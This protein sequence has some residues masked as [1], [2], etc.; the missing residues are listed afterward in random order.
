[1]TVT[2]SDPFHDLGVRH[3]AQGGSIRVWSAHATAMELCLFHRH[4]PGWVVDTVAL[5]RDEHGVWSGS[6]PD[7]RAGRNYSVRVDG[8][9]QPGHH[10]LP[11]RHLLDPYARGLSRTP[12]G[13][14]RAS[15]VDTG[16][17]WDG[18]EAPTTP[19]ENSVI[20]EAH[21]RGISKLNPKVPA[22]LRG[23]YAGLAH[24]SMLDYFVDL[25]VTAVQLLPVHQF[26]SEQRLL[27]LGMTNYWGYNTLNFFTP[28]ARYASAAAV[29]AGPAAILRE[30]KSMVKA[31]HRAGLQVFMDVVY[32]HTAEEGPDGPTT[33]FRGID[34]AS[35]YRQMADGGYIDMTGCGNTLDFSKP[36]AQR[37]V[38]D[39]LR[40]WAQ[41][42]HIDG[43]RFDLAPALGR[44]ADGYFDPQHPLLT[45]IV[46]DPGL[47]GVTMIAEPWDV[48]TDGWQTG[49]FPAGWAEWNDGYRG[50]M[51][52]F[53]LTDV[54]RARSQGRAAEG[55]GSMARRFAGSA[56]VFSA[57][58]GPLASINFVTAHDGFTL[59]DVTAY[60]QKHNLPNGENNRDGTDD[61]RSF[62]HGVE[63][64]TEN[65]DVLAA[66][67]KAMRN[68]LGTL[69]LSA[70]VPQLTA[71]D[72]FGRT[73]HGN[74][75]AYCH[76]DETTWVSWEWQPWQQELHEVSR[77]LL[78]LR[79]DNPA[80]RPARYAVDGTE[81]PS[82]SRMLW[83]NAAGQSM[84]IDNWDSPEARTLQYFATST[85]DS[86]TV[87]SIL[88]IVHGLEH[89][90]TI[91]L[92][93]VPGADAF[94]VVWASD[95]HPDA[96]P[97]A[98]LTPGSTLNVGATSLTLLS[99][100]RADVTRHE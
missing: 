90:R 29:H 35:Y 54:A 4:D 65:P 13:A 64:P 8:P 30:F 34:N 33:S 20:Y 39:S 31:F 14:F 63:G 56:H 26:V 80:L 24:D 47:A 82:A 55:I 44:T 100:I 77:T 87:N 93:R 7:L 91:T 2:P 25:G 84:S 50:R 72:E 42:V 36:V 11:T 96:A 60:N 10:F 71:G 92:P 98:P 41:E 3:D 79:R 97:A 88:L 62:N 27:N 76:D 53:W 66:R 85:A 1:M 23:T 81:C 74:N 28:H 48:G 18:D 89:T 21:A 22:P 70:G 12:E 83:F 67:R 78:R 68:L 17:D 19:R 86:G 40:Y 37:L 43:F 46:T 32:N 15:V 45:A 73:Q 38:L 95:T 52:D 69:L 94:A 6:H 51:R 99:V 9:Q 49:R 59:A 5:S 57:D 16:F 61:N 58:R 75:N